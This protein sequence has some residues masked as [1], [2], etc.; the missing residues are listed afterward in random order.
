MEHA[1]LSCVL[2]HGSHT[3]KCWP[4]VLQNAPRGAFCNTFDRHLATVCL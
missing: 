2:V 1:S 4:K 3:A